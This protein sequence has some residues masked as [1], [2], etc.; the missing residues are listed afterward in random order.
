MP[1]A[2]TWGWAAAAAL[3]L[4]AVSFSSSGPV[5]VERKPPADV[6]LPASVLPPAAAVESARELNP[7]NRP[8]DHPASTAPS[9]S[10]ASSPAASTKAAPLL[11]NQPA[12]ATSA[13]I[14]VIHYHRVGSCVGRLV[15]SR[16]GMGYVPD[17][18]TSRDA[19]DFKYSEFVHVMQDETLTIKSSTRTYRFKAFNDKSEHD[20]TLGEFAE[21]ISRRR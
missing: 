11:E 18:P 10:L 6:N 16:T 20:P 12:G 3:V 8:P 9:L 7:S 5:A 21:Q 19:F 14:H 1:S 13:S 15:A 17:S 2:R 4:L